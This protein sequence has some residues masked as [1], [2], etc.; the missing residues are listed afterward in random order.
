MVPF[1]HPNPSIKII[2]GGEWC[3]LKLDDYG[4]CGLSDFEF[5]STGLNQ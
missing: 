1:L 4:R 3:A 2:T 5:Q